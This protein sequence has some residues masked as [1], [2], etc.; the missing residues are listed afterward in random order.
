MVRSVLVF[1]DMWFNY[2][3]KPFFYLFELRR[4]FLQQSRVEFQLNLSVRPIVILADKI[5]LMY[6]DLRCNIQ[7]DP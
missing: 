7:Y 4:V 3:T 5:G 1:I 2:F 6:R